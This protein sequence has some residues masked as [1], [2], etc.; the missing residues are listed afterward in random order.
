MERDEDIALSIKDVS[1]CFHIYNSPRDRLAQAL[2]GSRRKLYKEFW[3]LKDVSLEIKR[4]E[5]VGIIGR[6]GSGKST[7]LQIICGTMSATQGAVKCQGRIGALLELGSGFNPEF[8]GSENIFLNA[9]LMGLS[10]EEA[11]DRYDSIIE[12]SEIDKEFLG[13]PIKSYSSGM[14]VRLAFAVQANLEP[15]IMVVD[16]ALAV[17]DELFQRKCYRRLEELKERGCSILLVTHNCQLVNQYCDRAVLMHKGEKRLEGSAQTATAIYQQL[18]GAEEAEWQKTLGQVS[19]TSLQLSHSAE[20]VMGES[21]NSRNCAIVYPSRGIT[22]D[23]VELCNTSG[24]LQQSIEF[25]KG[26][27]IK[28][29]YSGQIDLDRVGFGCQLSDP[30]GR[31]YTGQTYPSNATLTGPWQAGQRWEITFTFKSGLLPG[32]YFVSAG[33]WSE[34]SQHRF[35]HRVV[36]FRTL[37]IIATDNVTRVGTCDLKASEPT[38]RRL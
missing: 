2:W 38:V 36:D 15:E 32:L 30:S 25:G 17:G 8:S 16:E 7:L 18:A 3:A 33:V 26:F 1:K 37:R 27:Q 28:I 29:Q 4:G 22:I 34:E 21:M 14:I 5:T 24:L 11:R 35:I 12:F 10:E 13:Q 20:T 6:N 31:R 9:M 19:E 23:E